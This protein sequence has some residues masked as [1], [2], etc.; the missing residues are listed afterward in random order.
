MVCTGIGG[1]Y[2]TAAII[3]S[4]YA[5]RRYRGTLIALSF[6]MELLGNLLAAAVALLLTWAF[7]PSVIKVRRGPRGRRL[8]LCC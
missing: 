7:R 4:E 8:L 5:P 3:T 1:E 2:S 6:S